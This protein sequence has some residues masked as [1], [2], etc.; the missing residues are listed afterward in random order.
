MSARKSRSGAS[1]AATGKRWHRFSRHDGFRWKKRI[2][3]PFPSRKSAIFSFRNILNK[4]KKHHF[5]GAFL[6]LSSRKNYPISCPFHPSSTTEYQSKFQYLSF[7][8]LEH[9]YKTSAPRHWMP[10]MQS[11]SLYSDFL[12]VVSIQKAFFVPHQNVDSS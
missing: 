3:L 2:F 12:I 5:R 8:N 10:L 4:S 9:F 11:M 1:P 7:P 6:C